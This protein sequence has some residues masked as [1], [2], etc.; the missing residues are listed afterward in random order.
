MSLL[1]IGAAAQSRARRPLRGRVVLAVSLELEEG[2]RGNS[3]RLDSSSVERAAVVL[4]SVVGGGVRGGGAWW[5]GGISSGDA[6]RRHIL[7]SVVE[8]SMMVWRV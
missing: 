8:M 1:S 3:A 5:S 2:G 7:G 4:G 6:E